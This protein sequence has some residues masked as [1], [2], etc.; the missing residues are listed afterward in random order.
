MPR[1]HLF[2]VTGTL[3]ANGEL[4]LKHEPGVT[5]RISELCIEPATEDVLLT[6]LLVCETQQLAKGTHHPATSI[7]GQM[8]AIDEGHPFT[9]TLKSQRPT[10][11]EITITAYP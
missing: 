7:N 11:V 5:L 10:D 6:S 8:I 4:T 9:F 1:R 2:K 3:P